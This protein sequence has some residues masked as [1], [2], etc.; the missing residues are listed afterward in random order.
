MVHHTTLRR[1]PNKTNK[2]KKGGKKGKRF[3]KTKPYSKKAKSVRVR[4]RRRRT[5]ARRKMRGG[6]VAIQDKF[7][8]CNDKCSDEKDQS[9][10]ERSEFYDINKE[11][12][13]KRQQEESDK[14]ENEKNEKKRI[15]E[16]ARKTRIRQEE[17]EKEKALEP[18][19]EESKTNLKMLYDDYYAKLKESKEAKRGILTSYND[20]LITY[21]GYYPLILA[22]QKAQEA[23]YFSNL[24]NVNAFIK[25]NNDQNWGKTRETLYDRVRKQHYVDVTSHNPLDKVGLLVDRYNPIVSVENANLPALRANE[26]RLSETYNKLIEY[27]KNDKIKCKYNFTL[28]KKEEVVLNLDEDGNVFYK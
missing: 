27:R 1:K 22:K 9:T 3:S 4:Q 19:I 11:F 26:E 7:K 6:V 21:P 24:Q 28:N 15:D 23:L 18:K 16:E 5:V 25:Y 8:S 14:K 10:R 12:I 13:Q 20:F 2:T 17:A